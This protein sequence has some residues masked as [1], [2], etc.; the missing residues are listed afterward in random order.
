MRC[1]EAIQRLASEELYGD[2]DYPFWGNTLEILAEQDADHIGCPRMVAKLTAMA[3][4]EMVMFLGDDTIPQ[5]GFLREALA[6]MEALPDGW[7]L[8]A[9]NDGIH[10]GRLATHWLAHKKLLEHT[11]GE[12]FHTGYSH[13]FCDRELTDIAQSLGRYVYAEKAVIVHDHPHRTREE[14]DEHYKRAYAKEVF[15]ADKRLYLRRKIARNGFKLAIAFPLVDKDVPAQFAIS[16]LAM[17]KPDDWTLLVPRFPAGKFHDSIASVRN[18]IVEQALEHGCSHLLMAD[19]DQVYPCDTL[20]RLL[21]HDK[22]IVG[23]AVHRRYPPFERIMMRGELG[24]F[25]PVPKEE[26]YSGELVEVDATGT[27]CVLFDMNVFLDVPYPWF[28]FTTFNGRTVGEDFNFCVK[29]R[30][31]GIPVH[32]DTGIEVDHLTTFRV[33]TGIAKLFQKFNCGVDDAGKRQ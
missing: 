32:V 19:T 9:L 17:D 27:G 4:G 2:A 33:N 6:A 1:V 24:A 26:A 25:T 20:S 5:P 12:F 22:P 31:R 10:N 18:D 28:E 8:V 15:E 21:S 11:G 3:Q 30:N 14:Y 13:C 7:G 23:V 16:M 29:A